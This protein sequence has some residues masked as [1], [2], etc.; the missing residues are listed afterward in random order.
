VPGEKVVSSDARWLAL[1]RP[2]VSHHIIELFDQ[3]TKT[4]TIFFH[5]NIEVQLVDLNFSADSKT[6]TFI[7]SPWSG[8]G[9]SEI[10]IVD[11]P[12]LKISRFGET[13]HTYRFP[14]A[15]NPQKD[16]MFLEGKGGLWKPELSLL[17]QASH[18]SV[19]YYVG[20]RRAD[21]DV[22]YLLNIADGGMGSVEGKEQSLF[23][24]FRR[25]PKDF[26]EVVA[27]PRLGVAAGPG[28]ER[29]MIYDSLA[30]L[31][32]GMGYM[33]DKRGKIKI[34]LADAANSKVEVQ[35]VDF[36]DEVERLDG[37]GRVWKYPPDFSLE[38]TEI[39]RVQTF[40]LEMAEIQ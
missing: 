20:V 6:F 3:Q 2:D 8:F 5:P 11:L 35:N 34:D 27:N 23:A 37:T 13:G 21:S 9:I 24:P 32:P 31:R 30:R 39:T 15:I 14:I 36:Q 10:F 22:S 4:K 17:L 28:F 33:P 29:V 25:S 19:A 1:A 12:N 18:E 38:A 7:G 40:C 16:L 26:L